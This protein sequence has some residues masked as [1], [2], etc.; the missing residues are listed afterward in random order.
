MF[1]RFLR[2]KASK[3]RAAWT[4][5]PRPL[6]ERRAGPVGASNFQANRQAVGG[7]PTRLALCRDEILVGHFLP[8]SGDG[9]RYA[10]IAAMAHQATND[11]KL[12]RAHFSGVTWIA[13]ATVAIAIA[14][15]VV[16]AVW[17]PSDP[18]IPGVSR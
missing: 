4:A 7:E 9:T 15:L 17:S 5:K 14:L 18:I 6:L 16:W 2:V 8:G 1:A 3:K 11:K 13:L 10:M 12:P